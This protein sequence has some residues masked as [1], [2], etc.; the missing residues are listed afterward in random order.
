MLIIGSHI[1]NKP[2]LLESI[3]EI[4][5]WGGNTFQIFIGDPQSSTLNTKLKFNPL[6]FSQIR[7]FCNQHNLKGI[8]HS[9]YKLNLS[10]PIQQNKPSLNNL[11]FD[12]NSSSILNFIGVIIHMG[13]QINSSSYQEAF[14][15]F[16]ESIIYVLN[17]TEKQSYLFNKNG[18]RNPKWIKPTLILETSAGEGSRIGKTKEDLLKILNKIPKKYWKRLGLCIDTAHIWAAGECINNKKLLE[19]Y[20]SFMEKGLGNNMIKV[21]HLNDTSVVCGSGVDRHLGIGK[22]NIFKGREGKE[23]LGWLV[24]WCKKRSVPMIL[25]THGDYKKEISYIK[26]MVKQKGGVSGNNE[27]ILMVLND[28]KQYYMAA[29]DKFRAGAYQ[30]AIHSIKKIDKP[31]TSIEDVKELPGIGKSILQK[32]K[33]ILEKGEYNTSQHKNKDAE[34]LEKIT[35]IYG[36]GP[37]MGRNLI[38]DY[39]LVS[40]P[41]F[42]VK[43][44]K[45]DIK[46]NY[47][48]KMG[49]K[50]YVD[51][52][53]RI[54][55]NEVK[56]IGLT[57]EKLLKTKPNPI[58][59]KEFVIAG[60]Y[61]MEKPDSKDVD[62]IISINETKNE[63][64]NKNLIP[65]ILNKLGNKVIAV[66][67]EGK[68]ETIILFQNEK[69][70]WV[71]HIDIKISPHESLPFFKFYFCSGV[72]FN[73]E[74]RTKAKNMG[75]KLNQ[76]GI[77]KDDKK[78]NV[79]TEKDIFKLLGETFKS[80]KNR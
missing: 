14:H 62:I 32:I 79:K 20:F 30:K 2:T 66:L 23:C 25:E 41:D 7:D 35:K 64:E 21:I 22:G 49:L 80:Y 38:R 47:S 52:S 67:E 17:N 57:I 42:L 12:L 51:L 28:L 43:V 34:L 78:L 53:K 13:S 77:W 71:R 58:P 55:R 37:V 16:I 70:D 61:A 33:D 48:Q 8:I 59:I 54:P 5:K 3:Q 26:G 39:H 1:P 10:T 60:S 75:Y 72:N 31:I 69:E 18:L 65:L 6:E 19:E 36:I 29:G 24:E 74:M 9:S 44:K 76:Y 46:L 11:I 27:K 15:N 73:K 56:E 4:K 63:I 68:M 45:G 40:F 50:Y